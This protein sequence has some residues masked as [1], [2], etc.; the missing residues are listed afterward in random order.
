MPRLLDYFDTTPEAVKALNENILDVYFIKRSTGAL[1]R[2]HCTLNPDH[3]PYSERFAAVEIISKSGMNNTAD[4]PLPVWDLNMGGWRSFYLDS[5]QN[6]IPSKMWD[7][8]L[9][10]VREVVESKVESGEVTPPL[11]ESSGFIPNFIEGIVSNIMS[12]LHQ[13]IENAPSKMMDFSASKIKDFVTR[14]ILGKK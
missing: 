6:V 2:M 5:V 11:E 9:E 13:S 4:R 1:R 7:D 8:A 14:K 10:K 3:L 12:T